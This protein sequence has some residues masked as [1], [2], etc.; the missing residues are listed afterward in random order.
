MTPGD[1]P[2]RL[3]RLLLELFDE[4]EN[5]DGRTVR[6]RWTAGGA[7]VEYS[8][9][10]RGLDDADGSATDRGAGA[11]VTTRVVADGLLVAA[12][13]PGVREADVA[14][15][16]DPDGGHLRL[17]VDG[18]VVETLALGGDGWTVA[19]RAYNNRVLTVHLTHD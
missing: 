19:D 16:L 11:A 7:S 4:I 17:A 3:A 18:D 13:L 14:V 9:S 15:D 10:V 1:R 5:R 2:G 8:R 12:D 6:G